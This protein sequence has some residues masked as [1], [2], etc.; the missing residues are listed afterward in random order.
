M[1]IRGQPLKEEIRYEINYD[2]PHC[3]STKQDQDTADFPRFN[4][5]LETI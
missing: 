5:S 3:F 4:D 1:F 2:Q